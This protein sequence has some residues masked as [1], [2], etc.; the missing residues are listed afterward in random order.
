MAA[1]KPFLYQHYY[2]LIA[3]LFQMPEISKKKNTFK[4]VS[5]QEPFLRR[6]IASGLKIRRFSDSL[7]ELNPV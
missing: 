4:E 5:G 6:M 3:G 1:F 7:S 2:I